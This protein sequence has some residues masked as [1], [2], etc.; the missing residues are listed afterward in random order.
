MFKIVSV[1]KHWDNTVKVCVRMDAK[2]WH[3]IARKGDKG[4]L[5]G[6]DISNQVFRDYGVKAWN[7]AVNDRARA[8]GGLKFIELFYTDP[9]WGATPPNVVRVDFQ[10]KRRVSDVVFKPEMR[11]DAT[12]ASVDNVIKVDFQSKKRVA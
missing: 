6:I 1:K 11:T 9:T 3:K 4:Q 2:E 10:L 7:P 8:R 12:G 5:Y